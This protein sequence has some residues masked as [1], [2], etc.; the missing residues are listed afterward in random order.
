[1]QGGMGH[2]EGQRGRM[3]GRGCRDEGALMA[4]PGLR[5]EIYPGM[6]SISGIS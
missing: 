2:D 5:E 3:E 1:M 4:A 6:T